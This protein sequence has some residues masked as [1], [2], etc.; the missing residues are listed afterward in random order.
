LTIHRSVA[1]VNFI[2]GQMYDEIIREDRKGLI[3]IKE[4]GTFSVRTRA[5]RN[6][7]NP[8]TGERIVVPPTHRL[9]FIP[10][11]RMHQELKKLGER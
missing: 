6:G 7:V 11:D 4:F 9:K 8:R 1:V 2:F 10:S 5:G 3:K